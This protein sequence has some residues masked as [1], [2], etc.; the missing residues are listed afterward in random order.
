MQLIAKVNNW[1]A[2]LKTERKLLFL[3]IGYFSLQTL[4]RAFISNSVEFDEAEQVLFSQQLSLGYGSQPPLYEWLQKLFFTVFG[5]NVFSLALFK[6]SLFVLIYFFLYKSARIIL[7]DKLRAILASLALLFTYTYGWQSMH[8]LTHAILVLSLCSITFFVFLRLIETKTTKYYLLLAVCV[9][10]GILSKYN[11]LIFIL[12]FL[13]SALSIKGFRK[14]ILD[15]RMLL[16][17]IIPICISAAHFVWFAS[18][19]K[20]ATLRLTEMQLDVNKA[21]GLLDLLLCLLAILGPFIVIFLIFFPKVFT[22]NRLLSSDENKF[23][24]LLERFFLSAI[25][26]TALWVLLFKIVDFEERWLQLIF[27]IFPT[28][29]F[30]RL[31]NKPTSK[32]R[33]KIYGSTIVVSAI[34]LIVMIAVSALLPDIF[35]YKRLHYPI[36]ELCGEIRAEG[37]DKGLILSPDTSVAA[38]SKLQFK[39]STVLTHR[40]HFKLPKSFNK[41]LL[42]WGD[43]WWYDVPRELKEILPAYNLEAERTEIVKKALYKYSKDKYYKIYLMIIDKKEPVE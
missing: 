42:I 13:F 20:Q 17:L 19:F 22:K 21:K 10:L 43:T 15:K 39:D 37:F 33:F 5:L 4:A 3:L 26:I 38:D 28:Y 24:Q 23:K 27:F 1:W 11:Y 9:G 31:K 41:I 18:N 8:Q 30:L 34:A 32:M 29:L 7:K 40:V 2:G 16:V 12:A 35:G 14:I 6:N 36:A 25:A